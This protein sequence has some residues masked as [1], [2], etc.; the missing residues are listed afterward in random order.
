MSEFLL[1]LS[2]RRLASRPVVTTQQFLAQV[3]KVQIYSWK[4]LHTQ[5]IHTF[6]CLFV[7]WHFV[8]CSGHTAFTST[9]LLHIKTTSTS[10]Y[11]SLAFL[12]WRINTIINMGSK[13][14]H[15]GGKGFSVGLI[16]LSAPW[17]LNFT[18][19]GSEYY[20]MLPYM[21]PRDLT[22]SM[23]GR[24]PVTDYCLLCNRSRL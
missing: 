2:H 22:L 11:I 9:L 6:C 13:T 17:K 3:L 5:G 23:K 12:T 19:S 16:L 4:R 18:F 24:V 10:N 8:N 1:C 21:D 15:H 7:Y 20:V 14:T